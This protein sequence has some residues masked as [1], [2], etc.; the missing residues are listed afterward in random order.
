[1]K[2]HRTRNF[3][4]RFYRT[5]LQGLQTLSYKENSYWFEMED[6]AGWEK[7]SS[8]PS[9]SLSET[10][11]SLDYS[12]LKLPVLPSTSPHQEQHTQKQN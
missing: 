12:I 11:S 1:M 4:L 3:H 9:T 8:L 10:L 5:L 6:I 7:K 2:K